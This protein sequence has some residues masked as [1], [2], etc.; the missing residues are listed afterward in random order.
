MGEILGWQIKARP[1][2]DATEKASFKLNV[3]KS[4]KEESMLSTLN[5][6]E[7]I[8]VMVETTRAPIAIGV[9]FNT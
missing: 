4:K 8:N 9:S 6:I 1:F 7:P 5:G 2:I 3:L